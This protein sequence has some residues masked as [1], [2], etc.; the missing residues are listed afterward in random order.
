MAEE[1]SFSPRKYLSNGRRGKEEKK[2]RWKKITEEISAVSS[3]E[4]SIYKR[5]VSATVSSRDASFSGETKVQARLREENE[6]NTP[7]A[8]ASKFQVSRIIFVRI[9]KRTSTVPATVQSSPL[10]LR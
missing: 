9:K 1:N 7:D 3:K 5:G 2:E 6:R 10:K 4:T 8:R